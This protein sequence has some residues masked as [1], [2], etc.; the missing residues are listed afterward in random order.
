MAAEK[1]LND[2]KATPEVAKSG[3]RG[4]NDLTKKEVKK[5][6]TLPIKF[7]KTVRKGYE[8]SFIH[9]LVHQVYLNVQL[10]EY[11]KNANRVL[12][13]STDKWNLIALKINLPM[14]DYMKND[15]AQW[16]KKAYVRFVKGKRAGHDN[17]EWKAIQIVFSVEP[18][19]WSHVQF[20]DGVQVSVIEDLK[21]KKLIDFEWVEMS[22]L[23]T[24]VE[25]DEE[26]LAFA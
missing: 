8:R 26:G 13:L 19:V 21:A 4:L 20:L 11:D 2:V 16:N 23:L 10:T 25:E 1:V 24:G 9:L 17:K 3:L 15:R 22:D 14:E 18:K 5:F 12:P 7:T 6:L